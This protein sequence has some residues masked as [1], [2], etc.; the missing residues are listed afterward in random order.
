MAVESDKVTSA[1]VEEQS[2]RQALWLVFALTVAR[3]FWLADGGTDL[4]PDE[5]QYWFWSLH[6]ALGY[7]SKP[8][9]LAWL[10]AGT[11][12]L[13]GEDELA[14]RLAAPLLHFGT[15]LIVYALARRLYDARVAVWSAAAYATLPGVSASSAIIATDAPLLFFWAA[16]LYAFVRARESGG[17]RW[18]I[19]LGVAAGLGLLA[20]YAMGFWLLSALLFLL[21]FRDERRHLPRFL[22][23]VALA[24]ALYAPNLLWN[25]ENGFVSFRHT[26]DN[27]DL[28]GPLLHPAHFL[29]FLGSQFGVFGPIFFAALILMAV[30]ARRSFAERRAA[31]LAAFA[32]P[33]LAIMLLESFLSRAQPNWSAP[34]FVSAVIL[35]VAWL[36]APGR[37]APLVAGAAFGAIAA[38]ASGW[39]AWVLAGAV[40]AVS[41]A[42]LLAILAVAGATL[43]VLVLR[44]WVGIVA[45][46][47]TLNL[48]VAVLLFG[49]HEAAAAFHAPLA[50]KYDLLHR[51]S[52]WRTLGRSV[53]RLLA[54]H[55]DAVL[56]SD[57]REDM[58]ALMYYV[59]PHP[60]DALKWNGGGGIHDGFDL[61]AEP[62]RYLGRNFVLVTRSPDNVER[63][64][65]RFASV[66]PT[67]QE[68]FIP[69]DRR[70]ARHYQVYLLHDFLG[71]R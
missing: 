44:R 70:T 13:F 6:P 43:A 3:L 30:T 61:A 19:A 24:L 46:A 25:A 4:Y 56:L 31:L 17:G 55:P 12:A 58:A 59:R 9:L 33:T 49:G 16:A 27:V 64:L 34:T 57:D 41:F 11:T 8:P 63:I 14:V 68:I 28:V 66:D 38:A 53:G 29:E 2:W 51:L 1:A 35:V 62:E 69:L 39:G 7:Y 15:A 54:E 10:I 47:V 50:A 65:S 67:R 22:G 23:A 45:A 18:W 36:L 21:L 5:A 26:R 52:G 71:Y 42:A 60:F 48:V 32:L 37:R 20:K 40:P